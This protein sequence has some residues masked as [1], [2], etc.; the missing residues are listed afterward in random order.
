MTKILAIIFLIT[1]IYIASDSQVLSQPIGTGIA[2]VIE[3]VDGN[4]SDG[5][6]ICS[7]PEGFTSCRV[8]YAPQ[9]YGV[10]SDSPAGYYEPTYQVNNGRY[11]LTSGIVPV[12]YVLG[13]D[14]IRRGMF[15]TSSDTPGAVMQATENGYVLGTAVEDANATS[16]LVLVALNIHPEANL[17]NPRSNLIAVL[18]EGSQA[19]VLSPLDSL[20]Y[21]IA[22]LL[23]IAS[24]I[25]GFVYFGR[26][27][28]TGVEAIGRNPLASRQIQFNM[29]LH[30]GI[31]ILIVIVGMFL[32]YLVLIV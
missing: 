10:I 21:L 7:S 6:L 27:A 32:S 17:A 22:A 19:P 28:N 26:M 24:F 9:M 4:T 29:F 13:A 5:S 23:I 11:V 25:I 12:R 16:G 31:T 18:R 1:A 8:P 15:V 30:I 20:R 2:Q 14:L 3:M